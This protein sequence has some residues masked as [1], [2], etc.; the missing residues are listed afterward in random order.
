MKK[1]WQWPWAIGGL[2][3]LCVAA[4]V[5][6]LVY[7]NSDPGFAVE[8]DYYQKALD[9]DQH[10]AQERVNA[11]LGWQATIRTVASSQ[12][13]MRVSARLLDADGSA[14]AVDSVDVLAFHNARAMDVLEATLVRGQ[15][16]TYD[17]ELPIRKGGLWEFRLQARR[18]DDLYTQ[19][20]KQDVFPTRGA[21][22]VVTRGGDGS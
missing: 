17:A 1:G 11:D 3:G 10:M 20:I 5:S 2:L 7:A 15:D 4:N 22:A 6:L 13:T 19:I 18:G 8:P 16:G 21:A 14:V 9:W 12:G